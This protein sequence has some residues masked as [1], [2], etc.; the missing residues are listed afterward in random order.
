MKTVARMELVLGQQAILGESLLWDTQRQCWWWT[1]IESSVI[2]RW[3]GSDVAATAYPSPD[4]VGSLVL[5][6]SGKILLGMTKSLAYFDPNNEQWQTLIAVETELA[7]T[8]VNDG[9]TDRAGNYV[10]GSIDQSLPRANIA[11]FYQYSASHGLRKLDLAS[12]AIAN[13]ICF[14]LDD[15][16]MYFCDTPTRRIMQ[17]DYDAERAS[18]SNIR[19]FVE[20]EASAFPDGSVIDSQGNLWNAQWGAGRVVQYAPDGRELLRLQVPVKNPTCP[21]FGSSKLNQLLLT[22]SRKD[23]SSQELLEMSDAGGLFSFSLS[24]NDVCGVT[25]SL[26]NDQP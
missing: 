11:S 4:R 1:D 10:F 2:Y 16:T 18:V 6:R 21:A 19:L 3:N 8:R 9:R 17:C 12:A 7:S 20:T 24:L 13:S 25:D 23:M 5:C 22:T 26:F 15:K 14:S